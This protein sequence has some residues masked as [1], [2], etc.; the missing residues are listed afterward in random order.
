[1]NRAADQGASFSKI[2]K[3][4]RSA[5]ILVIRTPPSL[6]KDI[7]DGVGISF[8]PRF[9]AVGRDSIYGV[10]RVLRDSSL[11]PSILFRTTSVQ[12]RPPFVPSFPPPPSFH[13]TSKWKKWNS[14]YCPLAS[15]YGYPSR[16]S[17]FVATIYNTYFREECAKEIGTVK[18]IY[19]LRFDECTCETWLRFEFTLLITGDEFYSIRILD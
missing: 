1:M 17:R 14:S 16:H 13:Y 3:I 18:V 12:T 7:R 15:D 6:G 4:V 9:R 10:I 5:V 2:E 19:L 11:F 8:N